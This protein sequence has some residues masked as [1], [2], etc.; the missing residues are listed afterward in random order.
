MTE[1][2]KGPKNLL[3]FRTKKSK[4]NR[5]E[6]I[7]SPNIKYSDFLDFLTLTNSDLDSECQKA[8]NCSQILKDKINN[9][10]T[11]NEILQ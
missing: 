6:D 1:P 10:F 3:Q 2:L 11:L 5:E 8:K 4:N 7:P 9:N